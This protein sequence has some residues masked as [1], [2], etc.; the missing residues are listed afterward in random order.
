MQN[1]FVLYKLVGDEG[2]L[3]LAVW[4]D[5]FQLQ[6]DNTQALSQN[7]H[8]KSLAIFGYYHGVMIFLSARNIESPVG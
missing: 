7:I 6:L 8:V 3:A 4:S 5:T 1:P 2:Q